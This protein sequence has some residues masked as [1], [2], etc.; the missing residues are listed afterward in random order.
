MMGRQSNGTSAEVISWWVFKPPKESARRTFF[1]F[2][3][4]IF[5][6]VVR[7]KTIWVRAPTIPFV[8]VLSRSEPPELFLFPPP[9]RSTQIHQLIAGKPLV[10]ATK[11]P[12]TS[13]RLLC[14]S[15]GRLCR[16][17]QTADAS[18]VSSLTLRAKSRWF[19]LKESVIIVASK[20]NCCCTD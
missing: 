10:P 14:T 2:V 17:N 19:C 15:P 4:K 11:P 18:S 16:I 12:P 1:K 6:S 8:F 9:L 3:F 13:S 20:R 5:G 7:C